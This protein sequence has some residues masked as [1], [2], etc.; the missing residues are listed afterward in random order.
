MTATRADAVRAVVVGAIAGLLG[1]GGILDPAH[2]ALLGCLVLVLLS[3][4][5]AADDRPERGWPARAVADRPGSR[6]GV[7]DLA[8]Q[9]FDTD[10]RVRGRVVERVRRIAAARLAALGVDADD[11]AQRADVDRLLGPR[12]AAGLASG[13]RPTARTL[14]T[15]LDAID[16]LDERTPR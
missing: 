15:W 5:S 13:Q 16:R 3:L 8:C 9:V 6:G 11:P 12:V 10:S 4:R 7:S 14:Q 2:A 1:L